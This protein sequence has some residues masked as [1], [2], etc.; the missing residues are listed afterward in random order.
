[1]LPGVTKWSLISANIFLGGRY[2]I[3]SPI[4]RP[5]L[6]AETQKVGDLPTDSG[7]KESNWWTEIRS[8]H[9]S[10]KACHVKSTAV[11]EFMV[12]SH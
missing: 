6:E 7:S 10:F 8:C 3:S 1:M 4:S 5:R 11:T 9:I 12:I 2:R